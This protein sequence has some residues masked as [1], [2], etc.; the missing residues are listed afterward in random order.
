MHLTNRFTPL[1]EQLR[2]SVSIP[3][4]IEDTHPGWTVVHVPANG[5]YSVRIDETPTHLGV[6][7]SKAMYLSI[8]RYAAPF[9]LVNNGF[10]GLAV[11]ADKKYDLPLLHQGCVLA[12]G[13]S[14]D[15]G[16]PHGTD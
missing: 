1:P 15:G 3:W 9:R 16:N 2:S 7:A 8:D 6:E 4:N 12:T 11:Q 13:V 5:K 14:V 10:Y